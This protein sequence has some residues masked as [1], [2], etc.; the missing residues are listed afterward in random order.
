MKKNLSAITLAASV[1]VAMPGLAATKLVMASHDPIGSYNHTQIGRFKACAEKG[2]A[3]AVTTY[4]A[5]QIGT[6]REIVEQLKLGAIDMSVNDTAYMSNIQPELTV[7]QLPFMFND[8]AHA[9]R[10]MDGEPGRTVAELLTR[11]QGIRP[12]AFMHNGF[13]DFITISKPIRSIDDFKGVKLR[14]PPIPVWVKMFELL[15]AAP[16]TVDYSE[17]YQAMQS[18]LVEG[19]ESTAEG[20]VSSKVFEVSKFVTLTGHM[21]NLMMLTINEKKYQSLSENE[22]KVLAG[23]AADFRKV[24]NPEV[25]EVTEKS[26]GV[27]KSKG[28]TILT[29]D[30]TPLRARLEPAWVPLLGNAAKTGQPLIDQIA[31]LR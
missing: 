22:K 26:Y 6:A 25:I 24:G 29:L 4:P 9:E 28:L 11:N 2:G 3:F 15:G 8:W 5:G 18:K 17:V 10:A 20:F 23:C 7:F 21:Y 30:K 19:M 12:M 13:R 16:T 27:L 31:K 1:L 14:S